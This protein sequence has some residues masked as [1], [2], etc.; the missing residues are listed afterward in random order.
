MARHA[1]PSPSTAGILEQ[2]GVG[3]LDA[4]HE[5]R[6]EDLGVDAVRERAGGE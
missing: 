3:R 2:V 4:V 1:P 6:E 5:I